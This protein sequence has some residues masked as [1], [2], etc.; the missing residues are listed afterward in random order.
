MLVSLSRLIIEPAS[1]QP[2]SWA[3]GILKVSQHVPVVEKENVPIVTNKQWKA[4]TAE[5]QVVEQKPKLVTSNTVVKRREKSKDIIEPVKKLS[6]DHIIKQENRK[7][8]D[9]IHH[10]EKDGGFANY[11]YDHDGKIILLRKSAPTKAFNPQVSVNVVEQKEVKKNNLPFRKDKK[12]DQTQKTQKVNVNE[13]SGFIPDDS[14]EI[15]IL[16]F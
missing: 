15:P 2:D 4:S 10:M 5:L 9:R 16:V 12:V 6:T 3:R 13:N 8:L 7:L 11:T 1:V 14:L